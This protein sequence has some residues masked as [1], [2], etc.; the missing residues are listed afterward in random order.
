MT[1]HLVAPF[2]LVRWDGWA[3]AF[4]DLPA[5][6][7]ACQEAGIRLAPGHRTLTQQLGT[8]E[9]ITI[10]CQDWVARDLHGTVVNGAERHAAIGVRPPVLH[11]TALARAAA[12]RGLPIPFTGNR[13]WGQHYRDPRHMGARRAAS[14]AAGEAR[15]DRRLPRKAVPVPPSDRA[16]IYKAALC[17]RNWKRFRRT[18]WR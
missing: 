14:Q 8:G 7:R 5:L 18:R 3:M 9:V 16:D 6:A 12:E 1:T 10:R 15:A 13:H 4:D 11:R 2:L 17:N